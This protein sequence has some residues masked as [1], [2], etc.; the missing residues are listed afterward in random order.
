MNVSMTL[1][2]AWERRLLQFLVSLLHILQTEH[3]HRAFA[4]RLA[5][6]QLI[7]LPVAAGVH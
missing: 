3:L 1:G 5:S 2:W 6:D 4:F 7:D